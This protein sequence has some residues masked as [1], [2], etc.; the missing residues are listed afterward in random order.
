MN[1]TK[2]HQSHQKSHITSRHPKPANH[3]DPDKTTM[4][5]HQTLAPFNQQ[6]HRSN[7]YPLSERHPYR[8]STS[9]QN[10]P[11]RTID[12]RQTLSFP[13]RSSPSTLQHKNRPKLLFGTKWYHTRYQLSIKSPNRYRLEGKEDSTYIQNI[14]LSVSIRFD[15]KKTNQT[16]PKSERPSKLMRTVPLYSE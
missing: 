12:K 14:Q 3:N 9:M 16:N 10:P 1:K 5:R 15:K 8:S 6:P 13:F 11:H 7:Q 2:T 4:P